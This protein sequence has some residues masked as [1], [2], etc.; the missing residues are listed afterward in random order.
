MEMDKYGISKEAL[1]ALQQYFAPGRYAFK[2]TV[3]YAG[4]DGSSYTRAVTTKAAD[5][6]F[7]LLKAGMVD[8]LTA[9]GV[10]TTAGKAKDSFDVALADIAPTTVAMV[11]AAGGVHRVD[12]AAA[13]A[14]EAAGWTRQE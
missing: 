5:I 3:Q 10:S 4:S 7:N 8:G 6:A 13:A 11:D 2:H 1:K 12:A 9:V 14:L